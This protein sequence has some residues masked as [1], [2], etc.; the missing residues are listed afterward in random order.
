MNEEKPLISVIVPI[1]NVEEYLDE[2]VESILAQTYTNLEIILVDDGSPDKCPYKC[3]EWAKKDERV[4]VIHKK[5]GGLSSAR[6]AG[7]ELATGDY[8]G[9]VDSDDFIATDMYEKLRDGFLYVN[10][11]GVASVKIQKYINGVLLDF[12]KK[13]NIDTPCIV[14][15]FNFT[16]NIIS[17]KSSYTVWNKLFLA[18]L[19][20]KVKFREGRNNEDVLFLYELGKL[21][22]TEKF[23]MV[24][25]P[26]YAY[27]YRIRP[28]SICTTTKKP[29]SID[30]ITNLEYMIDDTKDL[31]VRDALVANKIRVLYNFL[32]K[33]IIT[34]QWAQYY[35]L[36]REKM[37]AIPLNLIIKKTSIKDCL[38]IWML[39][40]YP[41]MRGFIRNLMLK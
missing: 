34:P 27:Y 7:I 28:E 32:D 2:C 16:Y 19:V 14:D 13:W 15:G 10:D 35:P 17:G 1:F 4:K 25:L 8:I 29:L 5:N 30:V 20:K 18:S 23:K 9:F 11:I 12:N 22:K 38:W 36:Y 21:M 40:E 33:I 6:N 39:C 3:D 24:L 31:E 26:N 37:K 41:R